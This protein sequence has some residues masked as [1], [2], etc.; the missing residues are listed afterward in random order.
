MEAS[1][2]SDATVR[3]K[4]VELTSARGIEERRVDWSLVV[5]ILGGALLLYTAIGVALYEVFTVA[6]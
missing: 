6:I 4:P 2:F 5:L 3:P 1:S